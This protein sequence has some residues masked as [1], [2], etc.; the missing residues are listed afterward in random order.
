[1]SSD[2]QQVN[3]VFEA[4]YEKVKPL[5]IFVRLLRPLGYNATYVVE[6]THKSVEYIVAFSRDNLRVE[7]APNFLAPDVNVRLFEA[8]KA[9]SNAIQ[10]QVK[11]PLLWDFKDTRRR[12][13]LRV[14]MPV[15]R[16]S[17]GEDCEKV[18]SWAAER[19]VEFRQVIEIGLQAEIDAA[20]AN[21]VEQ[22]SSS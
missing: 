7:V 15:P 5:G 11:S 22:G 18:A 13:V 20:L 4:I 17:L 2:Q 14:N 21:E 6:R 19:L 10:D 16:E 9:R 8:L 3:T 12:Q 1:M